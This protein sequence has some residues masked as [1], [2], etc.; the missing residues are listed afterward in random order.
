MVTKN[1]TKIARNKTKTGLKTPFSS[2]RQ[3]KWV[4]HWLV[5]L[6]PVDWLAITIDRNFPLIET[7]VIQKSANGLIVYAAAG[8]LGFICHLIDQTALV[9]GWLFAQDNQCQNDSRR[10]VFH[11]VFHSPKFGK[12]G[13]LTGILR[14]CITVVSNVF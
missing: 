14:F 2:K 1:E 3:L 4:G 8:G 10:T 13:G 9:I 11:R 5:W 12:N 7:K 6:S